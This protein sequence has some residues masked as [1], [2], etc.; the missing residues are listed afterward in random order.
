VITSLSGGHEY[1][2]SW[3]QLLRWRIQLEEYDCEII[4]KPGAQNVN[5]EVASRI[6][7][8]MG[9]ECNPETINEKMKAE[10]LRENHD[11]I[12]EGHQGVN[13]TCEAI[14][15]KYSWPN[16]K[17]EIEDYVKKCEKCQ[18]NY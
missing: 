18:L 15:E 16:M 10:I 3:I 9:E 17:Q 12:L 7:V 1:K 5:A 8:I 2:G 4:Y 11:S 6:N 14:K 13:G